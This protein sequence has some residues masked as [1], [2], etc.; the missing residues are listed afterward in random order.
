[1]G[2]VAR[3]T[4][5]KLLLAGRGCRSLAPELA[6]CTVHMGRDDDDD[7]PLGLGSA[8]Q[9]V[10]ETRQNI[11]SHHG[12]STGIG[13]CCSDCRSC[14]AVMVCEPTVMSQLVARVARRRQAFYVAAALLWAGAI[15]NLISLW[16]VPPCHLVYDANDDGRVNAQELYANVD[17]N[18]DGIVTGEELAMNAQPY[19]DCQTKYYSSWQFILA[20]VL[21]SLFIAGMCLMTMLVRAHVRK[22]DSIPVTVCSGLDDCIC[23]LCCL[24][25]VQCQLMQWCTCLV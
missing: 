21:G 7:E 5:V 22:R 6:C 8:R 17:P 4:R 2:A 25:C 9:W 24:M 18:D 3:S 1:M 11:R 23:A 16:Y 14:C 13:D 20:S 12:W 19:N 10:D 15:G